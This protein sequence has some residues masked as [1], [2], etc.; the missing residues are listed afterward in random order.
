MKKIC[1]ILLIAAAAICTGSAYVMN[2]DMPATVYEGDMII[3]E[4]TS[5]L[6]AGI[7]MELVLYSNSNSIIEVDR[8]SFVIQEGGDWSVSFDTTGLKTGQYKL[9]VPKGYKEDLGGSSDITKI[10]TIVDRSDE[11]FLTSPTEQKFNGIL[12]IEGRSTTRG[13][14]GIEIMAK[15]DYGTV[16][17][18]EWVSTDSAGSFSLDI[19]VYKEGTYQVYFYDPKGVISHTEYYL[20]PSSPT[21]APTVPGSTEKPSVTIKPLAAEAFASVS[22][23]A[24]FKAETATGELHVYTSE[25]KD[26]TLS[27]TDGKTASVTINSH[28]STD[29][30]EF[31]IPVSSQTVYIRVSPA[32]ESESGYVMINAEGASSLTV[33]ADASGYFK[34][35]SETE[36]TQS[37]PETIIGTLIAVVLSIIAVSLRR[38]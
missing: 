26:W 24:Y 19:P 21:A 33:S 36:A 32:S 31:T 17:P 3:A 2:Y 27:Y 10:F 37:G 28:Q 35:P 11:I 8:Q 12:E 16:F 29:A 23:P 20:I 13:D 1:W 7:T 14:S 5:T 34:E 22:S 18:R 15:N 9:E 4:G 30:E 25:G 6:P 38:R